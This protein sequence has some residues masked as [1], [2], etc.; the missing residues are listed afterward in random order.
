MANES[1]ISK[2]ILAAK[3]LSSREAG[4]VFACT[5]VIV[6]SWHSFYISFMLS[7]LDGWQRYVQSIT[8][9]L[10][11]SGPLLYFTLK[12]SNS[13]DAKAKKYKRIVNIFATVDACINMWYYVGKLVIV[14]WPEA[15]WFEMIIALPI[16][17]LLP[18]IL[19][20]FGGEVNPYLETEHIDKD[21]L[22]E[23]KKK[24]NL[25]AAEI[26][27]AEIKKALKDDLLQNQ[28]EGNFDMMFNDKGG[29]TKRLS[30][31]LT[32]QQP[33]LH[34][35]VSVEELA[36]ST[37]GEP[38][39]QISPVFE[40]TKP[41]DEPALDNDGEHIAIDAI[42]NGYDFVGDPSDTIGSEVKLEEINYETVS[43]RNSENIF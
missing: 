35:A 41:I 25:D 20:A 7:S 17:W 33:G 32:K 12:A 4:F 2:L 27:N 40:S 31:K 36:Q 23:M 26:V 24:M 43:A 15:K 5:G 9:A 42:D 10:F 29:V 39:K 1:K 6:Q 22:S 14:P 11:M 3:F 28:I 30:I 19:K 13:D 37:V 18:L 16:A 21:V 38:A 34:D 8:M